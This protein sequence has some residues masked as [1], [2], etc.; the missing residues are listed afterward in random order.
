M[1]AYGDTLGA[2]VG[3][4]SP[5]T[6]EARPLQRADFAVTHLRWDCRDREVATRIGQEDA[7]LIFLQRRDI[8]ANPYWIDGR[9]VDMKPLEA[10]QFLLLDLSEEHTSLVRA[11]VDCVAIYVPRLSL[12]QVAE[13]EG[14]GRVTALR[15]SRGIPF[16]D[17]VVSDLSECLHWALQRPEQVGRLFVDHVGLA[18]LSHLVGTYRE[19][20]GERGPLHGGLAG[21]QVRR[22]KEMLMADTKGDVSLSE[23][24]T[25]CGLSG[26]HFARAFKATTG[27]PPH[28][29]Q[30]R[31]RVER[32]KDLLFRSDL[33]IAAV[34]GEC[35]FSDQSHFTRVFTKLV[36][37]SPAR[38]RR[39]HG[40]R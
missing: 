36:R 6:M 15:T 17:N 24:A 25:A 39:N 11:A 26:S 35:G 13:E 33:S 9:P 37:T 8:P 12:D 38:W 40:V 31:Q 14:M 3:A 32:A 10:R 4:E 1:G 21:W 29:W 22:A 2:F 16:D 30:L 23:I 7:F 5:P 19:S 20:R 28:R 27:M 18:L 34:A